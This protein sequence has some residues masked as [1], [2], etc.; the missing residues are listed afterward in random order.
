MKSLIILILLTGCASVEEQMSGGEK[1]SAESGR[2][3]IV[4][5]RAFNASDENPSIF[6]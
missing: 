1:P 3:W 4:N 2:A 6:H 5:N